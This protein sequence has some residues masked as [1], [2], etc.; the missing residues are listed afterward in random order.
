MTR[1]R[2][3]EPRSSCSI[4]TIGGHGAPL[5]CPDC[6]HRTGMTPRDFPLYNV[7]CSNSACGG[8]FGVVVA[9]ECPGYGCGLMSD[10]IV[11]SSGVVS[12]TC[13]RCGRAVDVSPPESEGGDRC[14][15]RAP[16]EE[17]ADAS[18]CNES[19][20]GADARGGTAA[21]GG[22]ETLAPGGGFAQVFPVVGWRGDRCRC[23]AD[24]LPAA[25]RELVTTVVVTAEGLPHARTLLCP[26]CGR[27]CIAW[28]VLGAPR[29]ADHG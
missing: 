3:S 16:D 15:R 27:A 9:P 23:G 1:K 10:P 25:V 4:C 12:W 20:G 5:T 19:L 11:T 17:G 6:G 18:R 24:A 2:T 7:S 8:W 29:G 26:S 14:E 28:P 13:E 21:V 22:D